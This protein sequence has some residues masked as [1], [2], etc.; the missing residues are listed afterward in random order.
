MKKPILDRVMAEN[1]GTM[2]FQTR[3]KPDTVRSSTAA[4]DRPM[5]N[6]RIVEVLYDGMTKLDFTGPHTVMSRIPG[7]EVIVASEPG[8]TIR[9]DGGLWFARTWR[10]A[11]VDRCDLLFFP[12]GLAATEVI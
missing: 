1:E 6:F 10:M 7:A 11:D 2:A 8:G 12:G 5:P 4:G 9:S 3:L